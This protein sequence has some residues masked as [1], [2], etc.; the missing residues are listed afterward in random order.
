MIQQRSLPESEDLGK[1][2]RIIAAAAAGPSGMVS[3][4]L[5]ARKR[6]VEKEEPSAAG[7]AGRWAATPRAALR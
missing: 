7:P 4:R 5:D 1:S 3:P 6:P 2:Q